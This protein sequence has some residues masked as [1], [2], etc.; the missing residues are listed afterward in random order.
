MEW[1]L[2]GERW[3]SLHKFVS[4]KLVRHGNGYHRQ[5]TLDWGD[6]HLETGNTFL[7]EI[8]QEGEKIRPYQ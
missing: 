2:S 1:P 7:S 6:I 8:G 5:V 3:L 4:Q